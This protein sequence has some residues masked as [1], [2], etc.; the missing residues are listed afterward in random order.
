MIKKCQCMWYI[1]LL[2]KLKIINY[3]S[4]KSLRCIE[5]VEVFPNFLQQIL[6][7]NRYLQGDYKFFVTNFDMRRRDN[8]SKLKSLQQ[9]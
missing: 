5:Y 9:L 8:V 3:Y 2:K 4:T 1:T 6:P 7:Q